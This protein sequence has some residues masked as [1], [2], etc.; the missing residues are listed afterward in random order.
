[1]KEFILIP[2]GELEGWL[3]YGRRQSLSVCYPT[4]PITLT[5][6]WTDGGKQRGGGSRECMDGPKQ[7]Q[8][9]E[10]VSC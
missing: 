3:F 1:M 8:R 4:L 10:L 2:G 5:L 9:L 6:R 7:I